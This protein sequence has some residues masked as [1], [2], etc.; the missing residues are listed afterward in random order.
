MRRMAP[1][2]FLVSAL[3]TSSCPFQPS[4]QS[5]LYK[6]TPA[7]ATGFSCI[8][9]PPRIL[10][11]ITM[12]SVTVI[13]DR[14]LLHHVRDL[15]NGFCALIKQVPQNFLNLPVVRGPKETSANQE[16]ALTGPGWHLDLQPP[17]CKAV[18]NGLLSSGSHTIGGTCHSGPM[19]SDNTP[20]LRTSQQRSPK[21]ASTSFLCAASQHPPSQDLKASVHRPGL[22]PRDFLC[23]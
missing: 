6:W 19:V 22:F 14:A 21:A 12:L 9:V 16:E 10:C 11:R 5:D 17:A 2:C 18:T 7:Q 15:S 20:E 3:G 13:A 1:N 4:H 8:L 23:L